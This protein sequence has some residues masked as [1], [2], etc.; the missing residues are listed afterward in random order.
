VWVVDVMMRRMVF[1]KMTEEMGGGFY[2]LL[3][4]GV[5]NYLFMN[6]DGG[7]ELGCFPASASLRF[8]MAKGEG[9]LQT[10]Q[11]SAW[12]VKAAVHEYQRVVPTPSGQERLSLLRSSIVYA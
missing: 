12:S 1:W 7:L 10:A 6:I 3:E 11:G 4:M 9:S 2:R 8:R 5:D